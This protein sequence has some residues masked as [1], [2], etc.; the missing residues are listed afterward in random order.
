MAEWLK[1]AWVQMTLTLAVVYVACYSLYLFA[2]LFEHLSGNFFLV[3]NSIFAAI[4]LLISWRLVSNLKHKRWSDWEPFL[5]TLLWLIFIPGS[6]VILTDFIHLAS[7]SSANI[8]FIAITYICF[9]LLCLTMG[10]ISLYMIHT[11]LKKRIK[12]ITAAAVMAL[13]LLVICFD[14]YVASDLG[15]NNWDI[16]INPGGYVFDLLNVMTKSSSYHYMIK[17][18]AGLFV[19]LGSAYLLTW[20]NGRIVWHKGINDLATHIKRSKIS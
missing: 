17:T 10:L 6:F 20:R 7:A 14:L 4:P 8:L 16:V 15:W 5:L 19:L 3:V 1:Q 13:I 12:P 11:E 2:Y 18:M 9:A